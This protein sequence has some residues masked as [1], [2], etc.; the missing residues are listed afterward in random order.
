MSSIMRRRVCARSPSQNKTAGV[1]TAL[2]IPASCK[3]SENV[4]NNHP[5]VGDRRSP[6]RCDWLFDGNDLAAAPL[7]RPVARYA[8]G[9]PSRRPRLSVVVVGSAGWWLIRPG[10]YCFSRRPPRRTLHNQRNHRP[11]TSGW[12]CRYIGNRRQVRRRKKWPCQRVRADIA[13]LFIGQRPVERAGIYDRTAPPSECVACLSSARQSEFC[14]CCH[15][16]CRRRG[17]A[18]SDQPPFRECSRAVRRIRISQNNK[19]ANSP[20]RPSRNNYP[21]LGSA[22]IPPKIEIAI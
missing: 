8:G 19:I 10:R 21:G 4:I 3:T 22:G 20:L 16:K 2:T 15:G 14:V 18:R 1:T 13:P 6:P 5:R 9:Y 7:R 11:G 12:R 17:C